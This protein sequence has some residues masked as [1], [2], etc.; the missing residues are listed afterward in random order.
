MDSWS[1]VVAH[2]QRLGPDCFM[3]TVRPSGEP[4]L[5]VVSP[6]FIEDLLV[7]ATW[8]T[9][10]KGRNL[11]SGSGV[12]FHWVVSKETGND[13]L[14]LRGVPRI[15]DDPQRRHRLWEAKPLPYDLPDWYQGPDDPRLLWVEVTPTY[16]S[17]HRNLGEQGR[18]RWRPRP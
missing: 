2:A 7:V 4:H 1:K 8:E 12:A 6:G 15:V 3:A 18:S 9:S 17:L 13:M 16:A 5:A 14:L 11:R 10:V